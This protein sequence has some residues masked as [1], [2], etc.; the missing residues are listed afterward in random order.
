M[1]RSRIGRGGTPLA[2]LRRRLGLERNEL[3][4]PVDRVQRLITLVLLLVLVGTAG[5]L[6]IWA[7]SRSYQSGVQAEQA[8]RSERRQIVATVTSTGP[9]ASGDRYLQESLRA[10]WRDA[11]GEVRSAALPPS[12]RGAGAGAQRKI[13]VD[14]DGDPVV[15]PRS[16]SRTV[17]DA[18]YGGVAAILGCSLPILLVHYLVRRRCDR[19]R[20]EQWEAAWARMDADANPRS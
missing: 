11:N 1:R 2:G 20:D 5:P 8:E 13:W 3:R 15:P 14:R 7:V 6:S 12:W 16:H 9:D 17:T 18:V 10:T 4:R 19:Y